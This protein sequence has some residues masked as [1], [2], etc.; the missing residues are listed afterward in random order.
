MDPLTERV[1]E[2]AY[3]LVIL[4]AMIAFF[5]FHNW[6]NRKENRSNEALAKTR[7]RSK[8][9]REAKKAA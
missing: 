8:A 3:W 2:D 5:W 9:T 1:F 6:D 7:E 4:M